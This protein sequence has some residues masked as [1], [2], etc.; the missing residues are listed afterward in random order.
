MSIYERFA[1]FYAKGPYPQYSE[2]M[3]ELLPT[4][5]E[6]FAA[7]PQTILDLACGE[8]AFVVARFWDPSFRTVV[9]RYGFVS[10]V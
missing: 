5:L 7:E 1:Y 4:V 2:R 9:D 10:F 8:G 3:V 6:R